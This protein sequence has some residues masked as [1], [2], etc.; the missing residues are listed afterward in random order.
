MTEVV[1]P[2]NV[3]VKA[4]SSKRI[5]REDRIRQDEEELERLKSELQPAAVAA[6]S[7][8]DANTPEPESAEEKTFKKRYGDL[9]RHSQK[10]QID[11]QA[12]LDEM[13][14]QLEQATR[15]EMRLPK[16]EE[17]LQAWA[18]QYPDVYKIIETI[19]MKKS[20]EQASSMEDRLKRVDEMEKQ[21]QRD[22]AEVELMRL[23]PDFDVIR[24]DDA[25]HEWVEAQPKWVQNALYENDTDAVSAARAIDLYKADKGMSKA[26]AKPNRG[27]ADS[28]NTRGGK[29]Q[30]SGDGSEGF[31][32]ESQIAKMSDKEYTERQ[33]EI[34]KAQRS[35][36]IVYDISGNA[37]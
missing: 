30:P 33:D 23:H 18:S 7:E 4:F 9:R 2:Q 19:A 21:A 13:K 3:Q 22:K 17:D 1:I 35:G 6:D 12:Q 29:S 15:K 32:Y 14:A 36:K 24:D 16:S 11:M 26:K 25:F 10:M 27:A 20:R 8:E 34:M 5:P 31:I 37:R 28:V